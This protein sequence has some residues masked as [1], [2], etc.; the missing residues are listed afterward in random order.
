MQARADA[1]TRLDSFQERYNELLK[2]EENNAWAFTMNNRRLVEA[3]NTI[4]DLKFEHACVE[5]EKQSWQDSS[6]ELQGELK[7]LKIDISTTCRNRQAKVQSIENEKDNLY[8]QVKVAR[9]ESAHSLAAFA[10]KNN[11]LREIQHQLAENI[12][13][14]V[15]KNYELNELQRQVTESNAS[16]R[17]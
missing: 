5:S 6:S 16:Y 9:Q 3:Y 2:I 17:I 7:N 11:E 13:F 14:L 10:D 8:Q 15:A 1:V 12:E 4:E